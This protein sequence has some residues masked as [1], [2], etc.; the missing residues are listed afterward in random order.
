MRRRDSELR[1][2]GLRLKARFVLSMTAAL[3]LVMAGATFILHRTATRI[4]HNVQEDTLS[5]AVRFTQEGR[6]YETQSGGHLN[7]LGVEVFPFTYPPNGRGTL[8]AYQSDPTLASPPFELLVPQGADVADDLLSMIVAVMLIVV[9]VGAVVALWVAGQVSSPIHKLIDD[10]RQIAR[11]NLAH[12]TNAVGSGEIE[13]LSRAIDR[14]TRELEA[15]QEAQVELSIRE[16]EREVASEVREALLP[17]HTPLLEGYDVG[18]AFVAS[19]DFGGDFHDFIERGDGRL[20]ILVCDV[21]GNG[22][23]AALVG[24]T[25]RSYLRSELERSNEIVAAMRRVNRRLAADVRRGMFVTALYAEIDPEE[26]CAEV[27]CAGHKIPLMRYSAAEESLRVVHP[28]GIALGFDRGPVF[29]RR[30]EMVRVAIEP[31]DRLILTNSAPVALTNPAG[32]EM[33]EKA[34]FARVRR[35]APLDTMQF[36]KSLRRDLDAYTGGEG[37]QRD[38]SLA[39]VVREVGS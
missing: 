36:L 27:I 6:P 29:D 14:M 28:E 12:R 20:G 17:L 7:R 16:R 15:A 8:Y 37:L 4:A 18:G 5:E 10:V 24:A 39:T 19:P 22:V 1:L 9:V 34:F 13:L 2:K 25:A 11:G 26:K 3:V 33:G 35:H 31:G 21:S 30:I 23:P 38:V 32:A